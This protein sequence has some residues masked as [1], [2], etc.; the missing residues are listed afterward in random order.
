MAAAQRFIQ[1]KD[2][3]LVNLALVSSLQVMPRWPT[4]KTEPPA[5]GI[6]AVLKDGAAEIRHYPCPLTG[7]PDDAKAR[8]EAERG[9][10]ALKFQIADGRPILELPQ[11]LAL[12]VVELGAA[13]QE[14]GGLQQPLLRLAEVGGELEHHLDGQV[15]LQQRG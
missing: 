9:L 11:R 12:R 10:Q 15:A 13:G 7:G 3:G 8:A 4:F 14:E 2:K 5:Y 1:T 6:V